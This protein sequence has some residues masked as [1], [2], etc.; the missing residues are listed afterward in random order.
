MAHMPGIQLPGIH[1][2]NSN[3]SWDPFVRDPFVLDP[4]VL[5]YL[6]QQ[7]NDKSNSNLSRAKA[8]EKKAKRLHKKGEPKLKSNRFHTLFQKPI[9]LSSS[10]HWRKLL[11]KEI[12]MFQQRR[13]DLNAGKA[14]S[15]VFVQRVK[16]VA[17]NFTLGFFVS[18]FCLFL[19]CFI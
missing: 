17:F 3:L 1:L 6:R 14:N 15:M 13:P 19:L 8:Q 5:E 18:P 7:I 12:L 9:I 10:G 2:S 16:T 4:F 11:I